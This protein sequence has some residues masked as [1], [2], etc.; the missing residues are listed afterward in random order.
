MSK[1]NTYDWD[2]MIEGNDAVWK[3]V[4]N[5]VKTVKINPP[6]IKIIIKR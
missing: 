6:I 4:S 5:L 2:K 1:I 3:A